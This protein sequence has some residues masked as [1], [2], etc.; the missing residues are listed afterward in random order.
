MFKR[1]V[2]VL[3]GAA[4]SATAFVGTASAAAPPTPSGLIGA[5]NMLS[6]ASMGSV[7]MFHANLNGDSGMFHAVNVSGNVSGC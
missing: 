5:C 6:D 1:V 2:V 7:A 3:A 4:L